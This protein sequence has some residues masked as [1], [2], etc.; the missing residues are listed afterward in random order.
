[1]IFASVDKSL[2][3]ID[4]CAARERRQQN[5]SNIDIILNTAPPPRNMNGALKSWPQRDSYHPSPGD[6]RDQVF[7]FLLP[8]RFSN[9]NEQPERLLDA[10][11]STAEGVAAIRALRGAIWRW[12]KWQ[13]SGATR[14]QGGGRAKG[15]KSRENSFATE[16][17]NN[18]VK[19]ALARIEESAN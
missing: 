3:E 16:E 17:E 14:F 13:E 4:L 5:M 7:Y 2:F 10:D 11:L 1:V 15:G 6:W 9:G 19:K 12:D 18:E 8:D